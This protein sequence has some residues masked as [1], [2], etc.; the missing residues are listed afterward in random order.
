VVSAACIATALPMLGYQI[1]LCTK[2][3]NWC[4]AMVDISEF[5]F[6]FI[7]LAVVRYD[8]QIEQAGWE[9]LYF[10]APQGPR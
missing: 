10:T 5:R 3:S 6:E 9:A 4:S 7:E 1:H 2:W 8:K